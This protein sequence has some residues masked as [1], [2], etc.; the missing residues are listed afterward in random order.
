MWLEVQGAVPS[1]HLHLSP[2]LHNWLDQ[3][4]VLDLALDHH[5]FHKG[6]TQQPSPARTVA[7]D[8]KR[9]RMDPWRL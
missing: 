8:P 5:K 1:V 3:W 4:R 9:L 6:L 7:L 2:D